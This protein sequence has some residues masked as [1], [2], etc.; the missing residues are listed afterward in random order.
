MDVKEAIEILKQAKFPKKPTKCTEYK[1][2]FVFHFGGDKQLD[3]SFSVNKL[4]KKLETFIPISLN[5][6]EYKSPIKVYNFSTK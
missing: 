4:T 6:E 5:P 3:F 1:S 2:C